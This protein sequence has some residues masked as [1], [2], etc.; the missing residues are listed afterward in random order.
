M[1][2]YGDLIGFNDDLMGFYPDLMGF[3]ADLT[4][5]SKIDVDLMVIWWSLMVI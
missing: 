3:N 1:V 2:F 5:F 4:G